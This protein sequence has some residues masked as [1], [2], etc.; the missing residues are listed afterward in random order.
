MNELKQSDELRTTG[1]LSGLKN[2]IKSWPGR[3]PLNAYS[4]F[5]GAILAIPGL[6]LLLKR[7]PLGS[8]PRYYAA[9]SIFGASLI[10][11]YCTS[12]IYHIVNG[13]KRLI[14]YLRRLDHM[15]IYIL[16]AGTY[17]PICLL[18][19]EGPWRW[20]LL[21][22]VWSLALAGILFKLVW[23]AAPRW[24]STASYVLMG[25]VAAVAFYPLS[26]AMSLAGIIR[27][28]LGGVFYSVGAV[29]YATKRPRLNLQLI[30]FHE[31]FHLLVLAGSITH[32][33][34]VLQFL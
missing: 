26:M 9:L 16:I 30:G 1:R 21:I 17:T 5:L 3:E 12:G 7:V 10:L 32:Y 34:M 28:I 25:W 11:L 33:I 29:I 22:A 23:F 31:I 6:I 18:V 27:L 24:L 8:G 15:M 4:H 14:A 2:W 19:L 13:S 20:G